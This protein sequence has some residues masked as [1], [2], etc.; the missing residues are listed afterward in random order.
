MTIEPFKI[1][2]NLK[3][4]KLSQNFHLDQRCSALAIM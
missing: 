3:V 1:L 2:D 4:I